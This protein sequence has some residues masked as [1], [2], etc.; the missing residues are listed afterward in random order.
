MQASIVATS[1]WNE[2]IVTTIKEPKPI[3][4]G[5][6]LAIISYT[7]SLPTNYVEIPIVTISTQV[8]GLE[9]PITPKPK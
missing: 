2:L 5:T 4:G 9:K 1:I 6:K 7:L 8:E 3:K